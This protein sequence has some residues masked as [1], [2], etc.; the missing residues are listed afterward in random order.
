M[1]VTSSTPAE[2]G[3][4]P[5]ETADPL[6]GAGERPQDGASDGDGSTELTDVAALQKE[7]TRARGNAATYRAQLL[8]LRDAK[9][10]E[11]DAAKT[12]AQ[13]YT[14]METEITVLRV[15][16][17]T[18]RLEVAVSAQANRLNI[19]DAEAAVKLLDRS[20]LELDEEGNPKNVEDVLRDLIKERPYLA[21]KAPTSV[22][23][24]GGTNAASGTAP[25]PAPRL[26]AE[27]LE[28]ARMTGT[29]P[30]RYAA[31]KEVKSIDDYMRVV[32]PAK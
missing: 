13:R 8:A 15:A 29:D 18:A 3:L 5:K 24:P 21:P 6:D 19:I 28:A 30:V 2:P 20:K 12:E 14:E 23:S 1:P 17:A 4:D 16:L 26:S 9:K 31:M 10:A 11:A 22:P 32:R 25:G 27:E 7:L